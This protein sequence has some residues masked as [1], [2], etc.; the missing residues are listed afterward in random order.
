MPR[1]SA[2]LLREPLYTFS[3]MRWENMGFSPTIPARLK[4]DDGGDDRRRSERL[5]DAVSPLSRFDADERRIALTRGNF[6]GAV[7]LFLRKWV[8]TL[9]ARTL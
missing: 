4:F 2:G 6:V 8:P 9:E 5:A 3:K 7:A 1:S